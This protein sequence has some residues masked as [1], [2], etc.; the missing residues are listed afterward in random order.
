MFIV[1]LKSL[2]QRCNFELFLD[3]SLRD[4]FV[5]GVRD[6]HLRAKFLKETDLTFRKACEIALN[7][8]MAEDETKKIGNR[9]ENFTNYYIILGIVLMFDI[10]T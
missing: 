8:E 5:C 9:S 7:W 3:R 10:S 2:A 1:E 4:K 6:N